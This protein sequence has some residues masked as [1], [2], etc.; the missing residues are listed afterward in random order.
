M[1]LYKCGHNPIVIPTDSN[2]L[3]LSAWLGWKDTTGFDGD[4]TMCWKCWCEKELKHLKETGIPRCLYCQEPM[5]NIVDS[6]TKKMSKYLWKNN[7][8]H[9][10]KMRLSIG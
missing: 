10:T 1:T 7:C 3:T 9:N 2:H 6:R 4:K 5:I 8:R